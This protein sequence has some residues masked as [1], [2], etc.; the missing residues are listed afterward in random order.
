MWKEHT[1]MKSYTPRWRIENSK[2]HTLHR[3]IMM[4]L[5]WRFQNRRIF[6]WYSSL[7]VCCMSF[8][9]FLLVTNGPVFISLP[10][11]HDCCERTQEWKLRF[12]R[13]YFSRKWGIQCKENEPSTTIG[14]L[15][16]N[17]KANRLWHNQKK[18]PVADGLS[19][20]PRTHTCTGMKI[21]IL[22]ILI[23][24]FGRMISS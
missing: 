23:T 8:W 10:F 7:K 11:W 21:T 4:Y 15:L 22:I 9:I 5:G 24:F 20:S 17:A 13:K 6:V 12:A 19:P 14:L 18:M 16:E 1:S 2:K 3:R